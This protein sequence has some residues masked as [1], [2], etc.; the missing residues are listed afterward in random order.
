MGK[1]GCREREKKEA[2]YLVLIRCTA[3]DSVSGNPVIVTFLSFVP[4]SQFDILI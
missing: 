1:M 2:A 4:S 3:S